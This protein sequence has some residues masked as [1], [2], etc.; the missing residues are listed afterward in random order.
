MEQTVLIN[1]LVAWLL[2][3]FDRYNKIQMEHYIQIMMYIKWQ[4][5]LYKHRKQHSTT[6][7]M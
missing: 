2:N 6:V 7:Y 5:T 1:H 4:L 3:H